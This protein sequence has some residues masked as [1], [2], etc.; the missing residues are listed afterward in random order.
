VVEGG[1]LKRAAFLALL[2]FVLCFPVNA[3][4]GGLLAPKGRC[5]NA[6]NWQ[7]A[8]VKQERAMRCLIRYARDRSGLTRAVRSANLDHSARLKNRDMERCGYIRHD[9]CRP[10]RDF[11]WYYEKSGYICD[12][13]LE[14]CSP[15]PNVEVGENVDWDIYHW[16]SARRIMRQWLNDS[17]YR[18]V[19]LDVRWRHLGVKVTKGDGWQGAERFWSASFGV[20]GNP[21]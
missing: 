10:N 13:P 11:N 6:T 19:V 1:N 3:E 16:G 14:G 9:P 7:T 2:A 21:G 18:D 12:D 17:Y 15:T 5:A 8:N 4:A 20:D